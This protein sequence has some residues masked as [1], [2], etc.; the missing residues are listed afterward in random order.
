[1][2]PAQ[3]ILT[4]AGAYLAIGTLFAIWFVMVGVGR[5]DPAA[6]AGT[7]GF[8]ILIFPAS[9]ALWP[10]L[11]RRALARAPAPPPARTPAPSNPTEVRP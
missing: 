6:R 10:A 9:V 11:L 4:L 8:R 7:P 3:V 2:S 1:M 5:L